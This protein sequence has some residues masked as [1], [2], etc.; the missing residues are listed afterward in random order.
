MKVS[1]DV[2]LV[3]VAF[4]DFLLWVRVTCFPLSL[5]CYVLFVWV[6]F[7]D[8]SIKAHT[9]CMGYISEGPEEHPPPAPDPNIPLLHPISHKQLQFFVW[10]WKFHVNSC[11]TDWIN[12]YP[13]ATFVPLINSRLGVLMGVSRVICRL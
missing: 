5:I 8:L 2:P 9:M 3:W 6:M 4:F 13:F 7:S 11:K 10:F 1:R 12:F